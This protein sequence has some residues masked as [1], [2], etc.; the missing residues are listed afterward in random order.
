MAERAGRARARSLISSAGYGKTGGHF[1]LADGGPAD[2]AEDKRFVR[3]G[4]GQHEDAMHK[5]EPRTRLRLQGGGTTEDDV[6]P[7]RN[8]RGRRGSGSPKINIVI[9]TPRP[10]DQGQGM[11][12]PPTMA[13]P[14]APPPPPPTPSP[15]P[16]GAGG[17]MPMGMGMPPM[18][19]GPGG[20]LP[21][22]GGMP[23]GGLPPRPPGMARGGR[24]S[25]EDDPEHCA[26]G[27]R[28][29]GKRMGPGRPPRVMTAGSG[30]GAGRLQKIG[31][32][33]ASLDYQRDHPYSAPYHRY[34][35]EHR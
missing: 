15:M 1:K 19:A 23:P 9:S 28:I 13:P 30:S 8:D 20:P 10:G 18:G 32:R 14:G 12:M 34:Q 24:A 7:A 5:G 6:A 11:G 27:G 4:V 31:R 3:R 16:G 33:T 35:R 29:G 26:D 2:D 22:P 17:G 21:G 25:D